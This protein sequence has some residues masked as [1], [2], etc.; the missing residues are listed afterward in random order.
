MMTVDS[1]LLELVKFVA[2]RGQDIAL[3]VDEFRKERPKLVDAPVVAAEGE[4]DD[5]IKRIINEGIE[6]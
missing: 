4:I 1:V 5:E 2:A 6:V 3:V